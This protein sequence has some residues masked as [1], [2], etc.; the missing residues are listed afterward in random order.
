MSMCSFLMYLH[1]S[2]A[3]FTFL[4]KASFTDVGCVKGI[5]SEFI[6]IFHLSKCIW[7]HLVL[8]TI[9]IVYRRLNVP[10]S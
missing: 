3:Y 9:N 2:I 7:N 8:T 4:C 5:D 1:F 6:F 10:T